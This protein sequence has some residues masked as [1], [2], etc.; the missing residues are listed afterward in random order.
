LLRRLASSV[1]ALR[2]TVL[3][4]AAMLR[5]AAEAAR[6]GRALTPS[7]F[8][9]LFP[10]RGELDLQLALLPLLLDPGTASSQPTD[11]G[12]VG[13]LCDGAVAGPDPKAA[14]LA[15]LLAERPCKTIVFS[16]ASAT[17]RHLLRHL[18]PTVRAA[19]VFGRG[20]WLGRGAAS[21]M[22]VLRAFAPMAQ[23]AAPPAAALRVDV[24]FATDL[25]SEG[26]NLQDAERVV[27]FDLPW[28]PA[29]LAQRVGRIDRA[30][31]PHARVE[32][33][34]FLPAEPLAAAFN[35]FLL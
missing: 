10:H 30:G 5:L 11:L 21:R 13:R 6:T 23:H 15:A 22:D 20:G 25:L 2:A 3:R 18:G 17:V 12:V 34:A 28:T 35:H 8:A 9:R 19:A 26:L 7:A 24:L 27:H 14:A 16:E 1:P 32:S 29:R 31:S 4:H 33:I